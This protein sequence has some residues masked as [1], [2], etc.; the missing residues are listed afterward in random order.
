MWGEVAKIAFKNDFSWENSEF[1]Q[2]IYLFTNSDHLFIECLY[3]SIKWSNGLSI[4]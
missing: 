3:V 2:V 4:W 1:S